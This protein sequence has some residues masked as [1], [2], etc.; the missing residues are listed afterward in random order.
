MSENQNE[1]KTKDLV[2]FTKKQFINKIINLSKIY[3]FGLISSVFCNCFFII[4]I[5]LIGVGLT[6]E[7]DHVVLNPEVS[8]SIVCFCLFGL[9]WL[10]DIIL[11]LQAVI[12]GNK[13]RKFFGIF[14][15]LKIFWIY[16][17]SIP[18]VFN[19]WFF[20]DLR[21][22]WK[23]FKEEFFYKNINWNNSSNDTN[24]NKTKSNLNETINTNI[25]TPENIVIEE[26]NSS[27]ETQNSN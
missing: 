13:L 26:L 1:E 12:V 18:L 25:K 20:S 3:F 14:N 11:I 2:I 17:L 9:Y 27:N 4:A 23:K 16:A 15:N 8:S 19:I 5:V 7:K 21:K 22:D 24:I 10:I 6:H